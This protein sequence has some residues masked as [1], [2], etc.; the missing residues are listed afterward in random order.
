[1]YLNP[2][3]A[4][5]STRHEM[6]LEFNKKYAE[7]A[8]VVGQAMGVI[9]PTGTGPSTTPWCGWRSLSACAIPW[10]MARA[11][12]GSVDGD[13]PAADASHPVPHCRSNAGFGLAEIDQDTVDF[14]PNYDESTMEPSVLLRT[15]VPNLIGELGPMGIAVGMATKIPPHNLNEVI[16]ATIELG[17]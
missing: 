14:V 8:K 9:I 7:C 12:F 4:G 6:G 10:W 11:I 17:E 13:R 5:F 16:S 15:R 3:I 1:M 2:C